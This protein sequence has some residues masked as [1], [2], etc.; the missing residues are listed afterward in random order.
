MADPEPTLVAHG[1]HKHFGRLH[2]LRGIDLE[3]YA[4]EALAVIGPSGS[5]KST[6]IRCLN[7]LEDYEQGQIYF[8]GRLMW[9]RD[10]DC[11]ERQQASEI[12]YGQARIGMVFQGFNLF[13]HL[14]TLQNVALAPRRVK[15]LPAAAARELAGE[16]LAKVGLSDKAGC[17]P[18][19]LSGG[20][21]QRVAIARAL[22]MQ[23]EVMLFDEV[24]SALD[25]ELV[26]EVL[27]VMRDLAVEG[28][29][30]VIVTHEMSF[31]MEVANRLVMLDHGQIVEAGEPREILLRPQTERLSVFLKRFSHPGNAFGRE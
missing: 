4:G 20:Q 27:A 2:V 14:N 30:M 17:Y 3:L 28:M 22:A 12:S 7:F 10:A 11:R 8:R 25:P 5:G 21:Q 23:P 18:A 9:Y 26:G 19:E 16:L 29:T 24:T 13:P 15:G 31:A 1:L 6:L